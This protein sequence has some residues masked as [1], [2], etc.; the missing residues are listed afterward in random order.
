MLQPDQ[1]LDFKY[2]PLA[3]QGQ[4]TERVRCVGRNRP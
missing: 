2:I 4:S 3:K 1:C